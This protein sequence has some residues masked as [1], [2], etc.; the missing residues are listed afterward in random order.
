MTHEEKSVIIPYNNWHNKYLP[1]EEEVNRLKQEL[2]EKRAILVLKREYMRLERPMFLSLNGELSLSN[3]MGI[4]YLDC[5]GY[6]VKDESYEKDINMAAKAILSN[7][8]EKT[9]IMT[10]VK[11][12]HYLKQ[13]DNANNTVQ[14]KIDKIN[15]LPR[16]VRWLFGI[17]KIS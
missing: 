15:S 1:M 8:N 6:F 7:I 16:I 9:E 4:G 3:E 10:K 13:I 12:K 14:D 5:D 17:K 2:A 11:A